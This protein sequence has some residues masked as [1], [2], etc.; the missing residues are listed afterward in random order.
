MTELIF[1][2]PRTHWIIAVD[3]AGAAGASKTK[4]AKHEPISLTTVIWWRSPRDAPAL[5]VIARYRFGNLR[6]AYNNTA[7]MMI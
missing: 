2:A 4:T 1:C 5:R 6:P 7:G 3:N